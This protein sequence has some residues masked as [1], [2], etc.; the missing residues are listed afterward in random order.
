MARKHTSHGWFHYKRKYLFLG[1]KQI[2][3]NKAMD[4]LVKFQK[5]MDKAQIRITPAYGSLLGII[6]DNDFIE[7]DEDI[8]L[9][10]LKED[11]NKLDDMLFELKDN[12]FEL[13]RYERIGLYSFMRNGEYIDIY[14][15]ENI[16]GGLRISGG[17]LFFDEDFTDQIDYEFKG[18]N[19]KIPKNYE[20]HLEFLYGDWKTPVK[21]TDYNLSALQKLKMKA[22]TFAK[23]S[24]PDCLF[25]PLMKRHHR[26]NYE[27]FF[28]KC[29][30]RNIHVDRSI[31]HQ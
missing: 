14:V 20:R 15:V 13:I 9:Y 10:M 19:I 17:D 23:N 26:K 18:L 22:Q 24:L 8:D 25:Y 31:M 2:D 11:E 3:K 6:R 1:L 28:K 30:E 4:N 5:L 16:G 7:W 21:Y 27:K 12:G 29:E